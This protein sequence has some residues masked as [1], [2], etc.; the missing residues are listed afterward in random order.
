MLLSGC[1]LTS[2]QDVLAG[3]APATPL[4]DQFQVRVFMGGETTASPVFTFRGQ[5]NGNVYELKEEK[6]KGPTPMQGT[7][8]FAELPGGRFAYSFGGGRSYFVG[9][10]R[11]EGQLLMLQATV[12]P[13]ASAVESLAR[14]QR[15][16]G[17]L[18]S[19]RSDGKG[20]WIFPDAAAW[21]E[22]AAALHAGR[23]KDR[24]P[25]QIAFV[26]APTAALPEKLT[27]TGG[28]WQPDTSPSRAPAP[29]PVTSP[30]TQSDWK[31]VENK[32]AFTDKLV[33]KAW[34]DAKETRGGNGPAR[35]YLSCGFAAPGEADVRLDFGVRLHTNLVG[36]RRK[37]SVTDIRF[38]KRPGQQYGWSI[39]DSLNQ[40]VV[41][42][43]FE[44]ALAKINVWP[45]TEINL[46]WT[47][48]TF[49]QDL[50][51]T[52]ELLVQTVGADGNR[53]FARFE[54]GNAGPAVDRIY[55]RC[56][57]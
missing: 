18:R 16:Q 44:A 42:R 19:V 14:I 1:F 2:E 53:I 38:D 23:I 15:E 33:T 35:I 30:P 49:M 8:R 22:F 46:D 7:L 55:S 11:Q 17:L 57:R 39:T 45:R 26:A 29:P 31:I 43:P 4:P 12:P 5:R 51:R 48:Y 10:A 37:V 56:P 36:E 6:A 47:V 52:H 27:K 28:I 24:I 3:L 41:F 20:N 50:L 13:A 40:L 9:F 32:D 25:E 34:L 54:I 21:N